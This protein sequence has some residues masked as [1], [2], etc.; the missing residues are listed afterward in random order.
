MFTASLTMAG[1]FDTV[2]VVVELQHGSKSRIR[3]MDTGT[4]HVVDSARVRVH[5]APH[6][7][8]AMDMGPCRRTDAERADWIA[9]HGDAAKRAA[10]HR[11]AMLGPYGE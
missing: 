9:E 5:A 3:M 10:R 4:V 2:P 1:T 6:M 7:L 8:A 11:A